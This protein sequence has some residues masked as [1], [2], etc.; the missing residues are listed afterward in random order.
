MFLNSYGDSFEK[1]RALEKR[2][3][4]HTLERFHSTADAEELSRLMFAHWTRPPIFAESK[5]FFETSPLPVY[6]VS[7]I[8]TADIREAIAFHGLSPA[9]VFTSEAARAYQPR[10]ELFALALRETGLRADEAL[11]IGDSVG[12][13]VRGAAALGIRALWI[14][15]LGREAPAGVERITD[16]TEALERA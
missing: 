7:N 2:S 1:Q 4:E 9:G 14:D 6:I 12:S 8:D 11:H 16:L 15:R 5:R 13:D 10:P 3:L